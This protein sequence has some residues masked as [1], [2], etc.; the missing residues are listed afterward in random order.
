MYIDINIG[1]IDL[2]KDE[3]WYLVTLGDEVIEGLHHSI[4]EAWMAHETAVDKEELRRVLFARRL[5]FA[6]EAVYLDKRR[7]NL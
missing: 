2:E 1:W 5:G 4:V 7:L 6:H 3:I